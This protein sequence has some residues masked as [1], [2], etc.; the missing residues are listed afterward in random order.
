MKPTESRYR[1]PVKNINLK[2]GIKNNAQIPTSPPLQYLNLNGKQCCT[3]NEIYSRNPRHIK[4]YY[5]DILSFT[6]LRSNC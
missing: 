6:V 5:T 4:K 1:T 2:H 3:L